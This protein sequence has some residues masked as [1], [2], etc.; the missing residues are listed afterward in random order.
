MRGLENSSDEYLPSQILSSPNSFT[1][2]SNRNI[3]QDPTV[4][5]PLHEAKP[6]R[7]GCTAVGK[8]FA[9]KSTLHEAPFSLLARCTRRHVLTAV[10]GAAARQ[11]HTLPSP[12]TAAVVATQNVDLSRVVFQRPGDP[13]HGQVGDRDPIGR[14]ARRGSILIVLFNHNAVVG[15]AGQFDVGECDVRDGARRVVNRLDANAVLRV[16]DGGIGKGD[17]L[18]GVVVA[19]SDRADR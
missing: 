8:Q 13:V 19:A 6:R 1:R 4:L 17:V 18:D 14:G 11:I 2:P 16:G 9:R 12:V 10:T 5:S 3:Q 15:D 7:Y